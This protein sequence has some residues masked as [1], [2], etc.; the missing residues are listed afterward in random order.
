M[1][2]QGK[3][4]YRFWMNSELRELKNGIRPEN[5]TYAAIREFCRRNR[6]PFPGKRKT[7]C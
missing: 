6:I 4:D 3:R 2:K 7:G 5:R 1:K